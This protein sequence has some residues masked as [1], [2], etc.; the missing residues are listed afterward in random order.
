MTIIWLQDPEKAL[1]TYFDREGE[2]MEPLYEQMGQR[3]DKQFLCRLD[4]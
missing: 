2:E 3:S 1:K 4:A